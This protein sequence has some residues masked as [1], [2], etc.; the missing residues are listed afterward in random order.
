MNRLVS[1]VAL[2]GV[3]ACQ[4]AAP[5]S[6]EQAAGGPPQGSPE[7][8]I[9]NAMSAAPQAIAQGAAI[10]DWPAS[11]GAEMTQLRPGGNGWTCLPDM[12]QTPANDPG[13]FDK[14]WL[15]LFQAYVAHKP[16]S[17]KVPG[18]SYMLQGSVDA[19]NA[20][21]FKQ[22][23]DSGQEWLV[24]PPHLMWISPDPRVLDAFPSEHQPE[25]GP[26]VMFKGT[27]YAHLMIP[28]K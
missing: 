2:I 26:Y 28:V 3:A 10:M 23:P 13:C 7:W 24:D 16:F 6:Q 21:P 14:V 20:D 19:S 11:E 15:A 8:K 25:K 1:L 22:Q 5:P 27:P 4:R 12:P 18:V 9:Q 17:T